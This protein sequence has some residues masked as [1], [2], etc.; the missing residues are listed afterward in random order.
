LVSSCANLQVLIWILILVAISLPK[1]T[2]ASNFSFHRRL[3]NNC[4]ISG[5]GN[6][7]EEGG[8]VNRPVKIQLKTLL[9]QW[10]A[11]PLLPRAALPLKQMKSAELETLLTESIYY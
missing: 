7:L 10:A 2:H 4:R 9:E 3:C 11:L 6:D 5:R 1:L 8:G